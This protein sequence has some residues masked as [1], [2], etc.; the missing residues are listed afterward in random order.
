MFRN[1]FMI[2]VAAAFLMA[3]GG[4]NTADQGDQTGAMEEVAEQGP[5]VLTL[6]EFQEKAETIV[7]KEV[8]LEGS[9]IHVCRHGGKKMFITA[10]DPDVR[11]KITTGEEMAAFEPE[12]EGNYVKV[13][14]FVE[15]IMV[16][17]EGEGEMAAEGEHED[18]EAHVNHYHKPQYSVTCLEYSVQETVPEG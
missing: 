8:V 9:V 13:R 17:G 14:G 3:C 11:I 6:A 15:E 5:L 2:M 12:L 16:E 7:G 10:D 18:D 1:L 4:T